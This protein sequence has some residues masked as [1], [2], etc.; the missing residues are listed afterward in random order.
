M[1]LKAMAWFFL[2]KGDQEIKWEKPLE[3]QKEST[4]Q[5]FAEL[6]LKKK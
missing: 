5:K 6:C 3:N 2:G 4:S 1:M